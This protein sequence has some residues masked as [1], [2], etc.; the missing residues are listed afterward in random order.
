MT[1]HA[2]HGEAPPQGGERAVGG[3]GLEVHHP[4]RA[5]EQAEV[6][7]HEQRL[8]VMQERVAVER[9]RI[10]KRI[11]TE[12]RTIEVPV[13]VEQ[14]VIAHEP[15][16]SQ[17]AG[18]HLGGGQAGE[19]PGEL[20]LVLHEE[21]PE[22]S[23]RVLPVERVVVRKQTVAATQTV[24]AELSREVADISTTADV[25]TRGNGHR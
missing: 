5:A 21:V 12:T 20:V 14:L 9:V 19:V 13:R 18:N 16:T 6:V 24:S 17:E 23:L 3:P 15:L 22:V 7:L 11:V 25:T 8:Q 2:G 10:S 4:T 1:A